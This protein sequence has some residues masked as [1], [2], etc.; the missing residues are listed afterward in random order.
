[1]SYGA[2]QSPEKKREKTRNSQSPSTHSR[3]N[4]GLIAIWGCCLRLVCCST[5]LRWYCL[6]RSPISGVRLSW[7]Q[8]SLLGCSWVSFLNSLSIIVLICAMETLVG[9]EYVNA[10]IVLKIHSGKSSYS[11]W[12]CNRPL[13]C[14]PGMQYRASG[15]WKCCP[16]QL[17]PVVFLTEFLQEMLA[18]YSNSLQ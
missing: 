1:M 13:L 16:E 4:C 18:A 14:S 8:T 7:C 17:D 12:L 11:H 5:G 2:Q 6:G 3:R 9:T 15:K 10:Q